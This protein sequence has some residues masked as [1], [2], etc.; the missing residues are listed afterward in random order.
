[1][2]LRLE[3]KLEREMKKTLGILCRALIYATVFVG[4]WV[5]GTPENTELSIMLLFAIW[6]LI[7]SIAAFFRVVIVEIRRSYLLGACLT[8]LLW[9]T[10]ILYTVYISQNHWV[11]LGLSAMFIVGTFAYLPELLT[12]EMLLLPDREKLLLGQVACYKFY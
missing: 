3:S 9:T 6:L 12:R 4:G 5:L 2:T 1:M 11:Y 10:V 8:L 7:F